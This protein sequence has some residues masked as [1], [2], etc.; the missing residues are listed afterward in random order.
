MGTATTDPP[1]SRRT[2]LEDQLGKESEGREGLGCDPTTHLATKVNYREILCCQG[3]GKGVRSSEEREE[4][5]L[6][7]GKG[8]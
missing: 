7:R 1:T 4:N 6:V 2:S 3:Q 5:T 8:G